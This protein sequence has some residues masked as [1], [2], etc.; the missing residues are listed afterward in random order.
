MRAVRFHE[1]G[2]SIDMYQVDEID[3][4]EPRDDEVLVEIS[5]S[6]VNP[7]DTYMTEGMYAPPELPW[8]PG[9]DFAGTVVEVGDRVG[10]PDAAGQAAHF[11]VGDRVFGTGTGK[12]V[13]GGYQE[14]AA[15]PTSRVVH[16]PDN[17]DLITAGGVGCA[18]VTAWLCLVDFAD[19]QV[20]DQCL[21]HGGSGGV[22]HAAVQI[23]DAAG[24][25]VIATASPENHDR[26][27][28]LGADVVLD[29]ARDD[30]A[31]A[32]I[33]ASGGGVD[34]ILDHRLDEYLDLDAEVANMEARV[35]G[36]GEAEMDP[37]VSVS[38]SSAPRLK[39]LTVKFMKMFNTPDLKTPLEGIAGMIER[40]ELVIDVAREY[41]LEEAGQA[42]H[43]VMA[44]SFFGKLIVRP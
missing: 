33:E 16:L 17:M 26:V 23:A 11:E 36:I 31:E 35:M 10:E 24:A 38:A 20:S 19:L 34:V 14:Y 13:H 5:A 21:I 30:L 9:I 44:D 27:R 41:T 7:A 1:F 2:K 39:N 42:H 40:D 25:H 3:R 15:I 12:H 37:A 28:E 22:G 43:D 18:A 8:V 32:I 6:S 29:Y 4:P